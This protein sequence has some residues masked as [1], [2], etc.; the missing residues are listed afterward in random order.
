M[1]IAEYRQSVIIRSDNGLCYASKEFKELMELF[2]INHITSSPHYPQ[3]NGF[4][5]SM[6]KLS[7]NLMEHFTLNGK[8]LELRI[9]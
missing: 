4:T 8:T 2:Q 6:M 1:I 7:K 9:A 3:S 5:E